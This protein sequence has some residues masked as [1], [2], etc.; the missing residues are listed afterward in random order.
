MKAP[1]QVSDPAAREAIHDAVFASNL[2]DARA[3]VTYRLDTR[4]ARVESLPAN[5]AR[6]AARHGR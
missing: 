1:P 4:R 6:D 2:Y 5:H 3:G